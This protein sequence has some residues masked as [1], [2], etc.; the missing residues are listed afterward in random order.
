MFHLLFDPTLDWSTRIAIAATLIAV[1]LGLVVL[2]IYLLCG[3]LRTFGLSPLERCFRSIR[4]HVVPQPGDVRFR[5]RTY[6]GFLLWVN[7]SEHVI[8]APLPDAERLLGRLF[9]YNLTWGLLSYGMVFVL[10]LAIGNYL[11]QKASIRR[12]VASGN[13]ETPAGSKAL[14]NE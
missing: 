6:R 14:E 2:P 7:Q 12:Q 13:P 11:V 3:G 4:I 1:V 8:V 9:W 5:Y 10:P